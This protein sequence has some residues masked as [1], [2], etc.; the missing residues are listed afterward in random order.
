[1]FD[2]TVATF[3]FCSVPDAVRG[4][5]EVN[6]VV[7]PGGQIVLLEHVR[8]NAPV[9]GPLM[10]LFDPVVLRLMGPHINRRTVENVKKAGLQ[11]EQV[12]ELAAGGLV[13]L[14]FARSQESR[15]LTTPRRE[16]GSESQQ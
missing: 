8:L 1:M 13:K 9:I 4:L 6:R 12:E 5:E 10:D 3:V 15:R 14:I 2:A 7:K 16:P 11:I